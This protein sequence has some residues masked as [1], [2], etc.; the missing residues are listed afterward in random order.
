MKS[1][2]GYASKAR[3]KKLSKASTAKRSS[4]LSRIQE[5]DAESP[6]VSFTDQG[7]TIDYD[8][9]VSLFYYVK[10]MGKA[11]SAWHL[12]QSQ[13]QKHKE[14]AIATTSTEKKQQSEFKS[15]QNS[16]S[17]VELRSMLDQYN[18]WDIEVEV[19]LC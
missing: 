1:K 11:V 2:G 10:L 4:K 16:I 9:V 13:P 17:E 3:Q 15:L 18:A 6:A 7:E 14:N 8:K 5:E 19:C 12:A